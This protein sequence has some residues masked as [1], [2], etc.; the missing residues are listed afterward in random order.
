M[1]IFNNVFFMKQMTHD[2]FVLHGGDLKNGGKHK[3][4]VLMRL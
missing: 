1:A 3:E 2:S 4:Y